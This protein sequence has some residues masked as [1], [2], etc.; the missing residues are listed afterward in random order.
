MAKKTDS[1]EELLEEI[2]RL[3]A[4]LADKGEPSDSPE[5]AYNGEELVEYMAPIIGASDQDMKPLF[6]GVNGETIAIKPGVPVRVKRKFLDALEHANDQRIAAW[7]YMRQQQ[8][9]GRKA[10]SE[11]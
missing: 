2:A 11:M 8:D 10:L 3:K 6:V 5:S 7:N 9:A 4:A 1:N